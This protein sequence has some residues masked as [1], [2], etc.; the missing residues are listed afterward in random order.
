MVEEKSVAVGTVANEDTFK[1]LGVKFVFCETA[2]C[3]LFNVSYREHG[4]E[5]SVVWLSL[6]GTLMSG[7]EFVGVFGGID[8]E[9][10]DCTLHGIIPVFGWKEGG[11]EPVSGHFNNGL[12][13][14]FDEAVLVLTARGGSFD[15]DCFFSKP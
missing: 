12:P 10:F 3:G 5:G 11:T 4:D 7:G 14:S 15:V 9:D 1:A 6:E 2:F 13:V 8:V